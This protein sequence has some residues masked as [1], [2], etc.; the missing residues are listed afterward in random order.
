M[1]WAELLFARGVRY[2]SRESLELAENVM[3]FIQRIGHEE[4]EALANARGSF[5]SWKG[6]VWERLERPMR[7][8]TVTTIAPTGTISLIAECSSGIE[9]VFALAF[10]RKAFDNDTLVYVNGY[11][12]EALAKFGEPSASVLEQVVGSGTLA[13]A[14]VHCLSFVSAFSPIMK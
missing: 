11:L 8:A 9:P 13:E 1:G 4:S 2:G 14:D 7:N 3:S 6:S 10:R 12:K 5:P